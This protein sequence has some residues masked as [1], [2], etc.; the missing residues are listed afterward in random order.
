MRDI[1]LSTQLHY[2]TH[3]AVLHIRQ[4]RRAGDFEAASGAPHLITDVG[5]DFEAA[6]AASKYV[7]DF[8]SNIFQL[9]LINS[10]QPSQNIC[11]ITS[12]AP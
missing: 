3:E 9:I 4:G 8:Y 6:S 10:C 1:G 12:F 5:G 2:S 11:T 7:D